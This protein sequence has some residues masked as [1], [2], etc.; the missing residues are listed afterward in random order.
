MKRKTGI[1][2]EQINIPPVK[3]GEYLFYMF[4]GVYAGNGCSGSGPIMKSVGCQMP[5][6]D[7]RN[8]KSNQCKHRVSNVK[9]TKTDSLFIFIRIIMSIHIALDFSVKICYNKIKIIKRSQTNEKQR[10]YRIGSG[11]TYQ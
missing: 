10:N 1:R 6:G 11:N 9:S 7:F 8:I 4:S 3:R 5:L 2:K